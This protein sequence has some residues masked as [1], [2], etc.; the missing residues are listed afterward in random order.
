MSYT[1]D[2]SSSSPSCA[3]RGEP[4]HFQP[5]DG[6]PTQRAA[7]R[8]PARADGA[9]A[10]GGE[11]GQGRKLRRRNAMGQSDGNSSLAG[12][13]AWTANARASDGH[14]EGLAPDAR[15][16]LR[17]AVGKA[18]CGVAEGGGA[19]RLTLLQIFCIASVL[20]YPSPSLSRTRNASFSSVS[21]STS[22]I[23]RDCVH[24]SVAQLACVRLLGV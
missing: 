7:T 23:F 9:V 1:C 22:F 5:T 2:S 21:L 16:A 10:G 17:L 4:A 18:R 13:G 15:G 8:E 24:R 19:G 14:G 6:V 3:R 11:Q 12:G 20:M